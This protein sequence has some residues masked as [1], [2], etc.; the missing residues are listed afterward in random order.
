MPAESDLLRRIRLAASAEGAR[1][2]RNNVGK[3]Q[4][5]TGRW[6]TYGLCVGSSDLIGWVPTLIEAH[7]VGQHLPVFTAIEAKAGSRQ[8]T[9]EQKNFLAQVAQAGGVAVL[10]YE[11]DDVI[12]IIKSRS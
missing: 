12:S 9:P 10:A 2:W 1:L 7:H 11:L 4:D 3:Y 5:A 8:A 6:V